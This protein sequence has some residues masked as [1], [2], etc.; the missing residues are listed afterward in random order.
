MLSVTALR[1]ILGAS[2]GLGAVDLLWFDVVLAPRV[3]RGE[4]PARVAVVEPRSEPAL[5]PASAPIPAPEPIAPVVAAVPEPALEPAPE[6]APPPEPVDDRVYFAT[7]SADLD[8]AARATLDRLATGA[9]TFVLEG[10][11]DI[12]GRDHFNDALSRRRALVVEAYLAEHGVDRGRIEVRYVGEED[13]A[14]AGELWRDRRVDI[15][16]T[17]G[18]R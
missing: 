16:I 2:L 3:V 7:R 13:A 11:A 6:P 18:P 9:G 8:D 12:R 4:P 15:Q 10:H 1:A 17:G 14:T 5:A